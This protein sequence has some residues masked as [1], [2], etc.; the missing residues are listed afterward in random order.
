MSFPRLF[1]RRLSSQSLRR[2]S[3]FTARSMCTHF[4]AE[5]PKFGVVCTR[6]LNRSGIFASFLL[7]IGATSIF[8]WMWN[9]SSASA[10]PEEIEDPLA[11]NFGYALVRGSKHHYILNEEK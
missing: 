7:G 4:S 9:S 1:L 3:P 2:S 8:Q 10:Q 6:G 5:M 11:R